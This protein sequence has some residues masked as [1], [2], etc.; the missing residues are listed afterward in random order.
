[1]LWKGNVVLDR[2]LVCKDTCSVQYL[3]ANANAA[4]VPEFP[5]LDNPYLQPRRRRR[6]LPLASPP[7]AMA[8]GSQAYPR[9]PQLL[10][11]PF[12][13]SP[14]QSS[15][16]LVWPDEPVRAILFFGS[17]PLLC[18]TFPSF[19]LSCSPLPFSPHLPQKAPNRSALAAKCHP[20][21]R[22]GIK[23]AGPPG[24]QSP[25]V[26]KTMQVS[27]AAQLAL[28]TGNSGSPSRS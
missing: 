28:V 21:P 3:S 12:T 25:I 24:R 6:P 17:F 14:P 27:R 16:D 23:V 2:R 4:S 9:N 19:M 11:P 7:S 15:T 18:L 26:L 22:R 10:A 20:F 8:L 13:Q 5:V 1:M